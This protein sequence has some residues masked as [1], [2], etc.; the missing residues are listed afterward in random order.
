MASVKPEP[1][2]CIEQARVDDSGERDLVD[3]VVAPAGKQCVEQE[4]ATVAS[5]DIR[6]REDFDLPDQEFEARMVT[7]LRAGE[8]EARADVR[9]SPRKRSCS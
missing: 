8:G 3:R 2:S 5:T 9:S 1:S 4:G 7:Q 6:G